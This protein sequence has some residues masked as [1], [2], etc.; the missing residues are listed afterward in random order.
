[1]EEGKDLKHL[2]RIV[3][4]DLDGSKKIVDALRKIKGVGFMF[5][6]LICELANQPKNQKTG[7][8]TQDA[9]K[10]IEDVIKN[11]IKY[12]APLWMLNRRRDMETNQ[13]IHLVTTDLDF[14]KDNDIKIMKKIKCYK[15]VRHI[16]GQPV[17]GQRTR[18]NFRKNKGK[19]TGVKK[20]PEAKQGKT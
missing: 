11:P 17:R 15:G 6:N 3:N 18:S 5:S 10:K 14:T 4:T 2:V 13:N 1:M 7:Y 16:M 12:G 19:V 20:S 8:L 9:V